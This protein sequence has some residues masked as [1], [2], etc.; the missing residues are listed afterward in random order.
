MTSDDRRS[1]LSNSK[2]PESPKKVQSVFDFISWEDRQKLEEAK[3]KPI[4]LGFKG[5]SEVL[6]PEEQ[7]VKVERYFHF[8][9]FAGL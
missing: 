8:F 1:M 4:E 2:S 6:Q 3:R 7:K 9:P 5:K